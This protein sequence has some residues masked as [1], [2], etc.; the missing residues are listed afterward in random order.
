MRRPKTTSGIQH[1]HAPMRQIVLGAIL[2]FASVTL[3]TFSNVSAY[4]DRVTASKHSSR[5]L[6]ALQPIGPA[7]PAAV[8]TA[9]AASQVMKPVPP[10]VAMPSATSIIFRTQDPTR[11]RGP[12]AATAASGMQTTPAVYREQRQENYGH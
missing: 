5:S 8:S 2:L 12:A 4:L 7:T 11:A 6:R 3:A 10:P 1:A 9:A